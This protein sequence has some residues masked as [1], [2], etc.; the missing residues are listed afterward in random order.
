MIKYIALYRRPDEPEDFDG[1]YFGSHLPLIEKTP[2]LVRW[3]VAKVQ[4]VFVPGFLGESEPYLVAEMY[5]ADEAALRTALQSP[6]WQAAGSNL[7]E[8]G[9]LD[10][11]AMFAAEVAQ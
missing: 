2:G 9:G 4:R 8:I 10:L 5:F 11:V 1:K 7:S 6:E 3:E